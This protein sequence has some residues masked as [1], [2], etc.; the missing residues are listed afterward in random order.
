MRYDNRYRRIDAQHHE[1]GGISISCHAVIRY[2]GCTQHG[3]FHRISGI[4]INSMCIFFA[5]LDIKIPVISGCRN[6]LVSY[7]DDSFY[8]S[9]QKFYGGIFYTRGPRRTPVINTPTGY[10]TTDIDKII[11]NTFLI[12]E[13]TGFE[14]VGLRL[15]EGDDYPYYETI[16]FPALF[17]EQENSL[18]EKADDGSTVRDAHGK[19]VGI[20][21]VG[22]AMKMMLHKLSVRDLEARLS[23]AFGMACRAF[24]TDRPELLI[25]IDTVD[26]LSMIERV[27]E[28]VSRQEAR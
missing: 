15:K 16:G 18:C 19:A 22:F 14:A 2:Y 10:F 3:V 9:V 6:S 23:E 21:G 27:L 12:K 24:V 4:R 13:F 28:N 17:I 20:L 11:I 7:L 5:I 8:F 26:D 25:S 1:C